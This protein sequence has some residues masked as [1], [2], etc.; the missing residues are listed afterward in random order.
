MM[1]MVREENRVSCRTEYYQTGKSYEARRYL[2]WGSHF[3][4]FQSV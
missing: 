1:N 4:K 3:R 2:G